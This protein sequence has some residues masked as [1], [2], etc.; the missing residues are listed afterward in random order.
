MLTPASTAR[1]RRQEANI[2]GTP[3]SDTRD[4]LAH[5]SANAPASDTLGD[6]M[7]R[8]VSAF[9]LTRGREHTLSY[10]N[11][12]FRKLMGDTASTAIESPVAGALNL[13]ETAPLVTL[14]DRAYRTGI[15]VRAQH[16]D[17]SGRLV[18]QMSCNVWPVLTNTGVTE[19]MLVEL[20]PSTREEITIGLQREV[21]ERLLVS[22]LRDQMS[23]ERAESSRRRANFLAEEGWRLGESLD[24]EVTIGAIQRTRLP[25]VGSWCVVDIITPDH[26][27]HRLAVVHPDSEKQGVLAALEGRWTPELS[28]A[29]GLPAA[30]RARETTPFQVDLAAVVASAS[31]PA[32]VIAALEVL[33]LGPSLVV[34]L[35]AGDRLL[36]AIT[37]VTGRPD[38]EFSPEDMELANELADRSA[39]AL[40][41]ARQYGESLALRLRAESANQVKSTFLGMMSHELRTPL[42]A[43]GGYVD[44]IDMELRGPVTEAQHKDLG[45][46]RTTQ[47]YLTGL[48]DDLLSLTKVNAGQVVY[49]TGDVDAHEVLEASRSLVAPLFA[50][51]RLAYDDTSDD[52]EIVARGDRDKIVQI[53]VNLLSNAIKF[54]PPG[55]TIQVGCTTTEKTVIIRVC[56]TGVGIPE[57]K[58]ELIFDPFVQ[59]NGSSLNAVAGV[60]LGLAIS[61]GLARAMRGELIAECTPGDGARFTLTLPRAIEG[62]LA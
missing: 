19:S 24:E 61:R 27:L 44:L 54:T 26:T 45:R 57:E 49:G 7:E 47:R 41:R 18:M 3:F 20:R 14:L 8:M 50:Q 25:H 31:H 55:G 10:A 5:V 6:V 39:A 23:A 34:P 22:A 60:G 11:A 29:F 53:L 51:R 16:V 17:P 9:A 21:A 46:I 13:R 43:I 62:C 30:L 1:W 35:R 40:D 4:A 32:D 28:D 59:L 48:I 42:N 33:G 15:A 37:F 56:D 12:A 2:T 36:G 58:L 52:A 38:Y